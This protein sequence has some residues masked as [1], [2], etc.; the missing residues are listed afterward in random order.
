MRKISY[1]LVA[2]IVL[3]ASCKP[4]FKKGEGGMEYQITNSGKGA[5]LKTGDFIELHFTNVLSRKGKADS[6]LNNTREMGMPQFM[7]FD[8]MQIPA[9]YF[10]IFKQMKAGDSLTTR[11][12]VD[13]L[14]KKNPTQ[15]PP[16]MKKG[17]FIYTN[18]KIENV[19]KDQAAADSA[20]QLAMANAE[21]LG[22]AKAEAL[23]KE[24]D[25]TI[26][27]YIA[28]NKVTAVKNAK[29]V[30]IETL[31]AGTGAVLD[32]N[33][34]VKVMYKGSTFD[35][36]MFDTNM[37]TSKGHTDPLTVNLTND[38]SLGNGVI[39]GFENAMYGLQRGS[40]VKIYIPSGLAYGARAGGSDIPANSNLIF[41]IE[42]LDVMN[43]AQFKTDAATAAAKAKIAQAA[44]QKQYML[45]EKKF[46]DSL[47]KAD[48]KKFEEYNKNKQ[49]QM[50]EQMRQQGPP[51]GR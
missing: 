10:G 35:G 28:K 32:T 12:L 33:S 4:G 45:E 31:Q 38:K 20:R 47:Q 15:T 16:F 7:P 14:I 26:A 39:P 24:D 1:L 44:Q 23:V 37:D 46:E 2:S 17:D 21:K 6:M 3:L 13:S 49:Q 51:Q 18:I 48:P 34:F 9:P 30:Y 22:K 36:H 42:V 25:K 40:R 19:Y 43:K 50:M 29:G 5:A 8:S 27:D 11:M 41:E